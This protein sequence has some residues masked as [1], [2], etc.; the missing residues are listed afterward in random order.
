MDEVVALLKA[1]NFGELEPFF[2]RHHIQWLCHEKTWT[3]PYVL[4]LEPKLQTK[5]KELQERVKGCKEKDLHDQLATRALPLFRSQTRLNALNSHL[6]GVPLIGIEEGGVGAGLSIQKTQEVIK[7][8]ELRAPHYVPVPRTPYQLVASRAQMLAR[9][10]HVYDQLTAPEAAMT[11]DRHLE[12]IKGLQPMFLSSGVATPQ[13]GPFSRADGIGIPLGPGVGPWNAP[14]ML[15]PLYEAL[16][17]PVVFA[18]LRVKHRGKAPERVEATFKAPF[19]SGRWLVLQLPP[20]QMRDASTFLPIA[21]IL[22]GVRLQ[23]LVPEGIEGW[24]RVEEK[25][26]EQEQKMLDA[27]VT[28]FRMRCW[29]G[30]TEGGGAAV[31]YERQLVKDG[32]RAILEGR[33]SIPPSLPHAEVLR[34]WLGPAGN[35]A[36]ASSGFGFQERGRLLFFIGR[37]M[38]TKETWPLWSA[39][40]A[41]HQK[42]ARDLVAILDK[43]AEWRATE[44][45]RLGRPW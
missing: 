10:A 20:P 44:G 25:Y 9:L 13:D 43:C 26:G 22:E 32:G 41:Q 12:S 30:E 8:T 24:E 29:T 18:Y 1:L 14:G 35:S 40:A 45:R 4:A 19:Q 23:V 34:V 17:K 11:F 15:C 16:E 39:K 36:G 28:G 42:C 38:M 2:Q 3:S 5:L 31:D 27:L 21:S 7:A 37:G 6:S 33:A